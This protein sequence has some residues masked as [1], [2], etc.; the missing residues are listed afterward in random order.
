MGG[1]KML[2]LPRLPR[3]KAGEAVEVDAIWKRGRVNR[4]FWHKSLE[5]FFYYLDGVDFNPSVPYSESKLCKS[6]EGRLAFESVL[7]DR[8]SRVYVEE[9]AR[10]KFYYTAW[11]EGV[12]IGVASTP[13]IAYIGACVNGSRAC[14]EYC[15]AEELQE[16]T[17]EI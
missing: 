9:K 5:Q 12:I 7:R 4:F 2:K 14:M 3:F 15:A 10:G 13:D 11:V 8:L 16:R 1:L 6:P 17:R